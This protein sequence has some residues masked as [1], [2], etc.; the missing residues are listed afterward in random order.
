MAELPKGRRTTSFL[1]H[2]SLADQSFSLHFLPWQHISC[3][4]PNNCIDK[5][6]LTLNIAVVLYRANCGPT[7]RA[8][9]ASPSRPS[10][11]RSLTMAGTSTSGADSDMVRRYNVARSCIRCHQRKIRCDKATPCAA[12]VKAGDRSSCRYPA[13]TKAKRRAVKADSL[14]LQVER[15][16]RLVADRT[17]QPPA[18]NTNSAHQ[19]SSSAAAVGVLVK[20]GHWVRYI[21]DQVL[22]HILEKVRMV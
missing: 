18:R 1:P 11:A 4:T 12:C 16:E 8:M 7:T 2:H 21:N 9:V 14:Q 13:D 6:R 10:T 19:S 5:R 3:G 17:N 15:L 20:D 22:S